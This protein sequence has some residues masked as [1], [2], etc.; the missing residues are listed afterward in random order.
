VVG[1]NS[2]MAIVMSSERTKTVL[3]RMGAQLITSFWARQSTYVVRRG[4]LIF[5]IKCGFRVVI[6][7]RLRCLERH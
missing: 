5:G 4:V 2:T 7:L 3:Y 1:L 6:V